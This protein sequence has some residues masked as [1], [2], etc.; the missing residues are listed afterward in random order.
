MSLHAR[1]LHDIFFTLS[2]ILSFRNFAIRVPF[3]VY[4]DVSTMSH[5]ELSLVFFPLLT[6]LAPWLRAIARIK[7]FVWFVLSCDPSRWSKCYP[8][9]CHASPPST[10]HI[11]T[12]HIWIFS[13]LFARDLFLPHSLPSH[14]VSYCI[15]LAL[16]L[17][18]SLRS[19]LY[20]PHFIFLINNVPG[21][22]DRMGQVATRGP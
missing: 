19:H 10:F 16:S 7:S 11:D 18:L 21:R 20:S 5:R 14:G 13:P 6:F 9:F 3:F 15:T 8:R 1:L 22:V 2:S 17:S 4:Q 12:V